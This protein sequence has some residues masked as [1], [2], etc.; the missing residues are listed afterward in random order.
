MPA[1]LVT[2]V[3]PQIHRIYYDEDIYANMGQ[4]I[5]YT[6]QAGM[7]NY[8]TFEYG[9]YFVNWLLYNKDPAGWPFLMSLVFQLFGT[10]ETLAFYLNNLLFAGGI[11]IVFFITRMIVGGSPLPALLAQA[12][13][14]LQGPRLSSRAGRLPSGVLRD[15]RAPHGVRAPVLQLR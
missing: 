13:E 2:L 4:N 14:A 12:P 9:E 15:P 7:A 6:G 5:A 11:L 8:G 1:L 3:A 10:D